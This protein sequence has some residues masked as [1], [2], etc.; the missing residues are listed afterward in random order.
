MKKLFFSIL[1]LSV[2]LFGL[3]AFSNGDTDQQEERR[4][5]VV[6]PSKLDRDIL[7]FKLFADALQEFNRR[8]VW[9]AEKKFIHETCIPQLKPILKNLETLIGEVRDAGKFEEFRSSF[10]LCM[11]ELQDYFDRLFDIRFYRMVD[12]YNEWCE[13]FVEEAFKSTSDIL[14][15]FEKQKRL[16]E[17]RE[18]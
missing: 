9:G 7:L 18:R 4:L 16:I 3:S 17:T 1:V 13:E 12:P 14:T 2:V 8:R 5:N 6:L 11:D 10:L 15:R